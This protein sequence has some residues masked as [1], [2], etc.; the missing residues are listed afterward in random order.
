MK[1]KPN[2]GVI[3]CFGELDYMYFN[4]LECPFQFTMKI[5]SLEEMASH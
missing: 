3:K 2:F 5:S 4:Y 1:V